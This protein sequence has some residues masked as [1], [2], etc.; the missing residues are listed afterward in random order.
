MSNNDLIRRI[1][2]LERKL[3]I[4]T[5]FVDNLSNQQLRMLDLIDE[6]L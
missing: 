3:D 2:S 5:Q 6:T 1:E 4:L